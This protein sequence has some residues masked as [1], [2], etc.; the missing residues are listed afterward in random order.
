MQRRDA[1]RAPRHG[2][3]Q[4]IHVAEDAGGDRAEAAHG[5]ERD[6]HAKPERI[7]RERAHRVGGE[8]PGPEGDGKRHQHQV[9]G[10]TAKRRFP[11][12]PALFAAK[13]GSLFLALAA[14]AAEAASPEVRQT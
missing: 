5:D 8:R 1:S 4:V 9:D 6:A 11:L 10:M 2:Y 13:A 3:R 12:H 14:A 7:V